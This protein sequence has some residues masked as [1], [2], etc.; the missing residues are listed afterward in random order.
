MIATIFALFRCG[1]SVALVNPRLYPHLRSA[2]VRNLIYD[3]QGQVLSGGRNIRFDMSWLPA[4]V[5]R[6]AARAPYRHR[7][8]GDGNLISFTSGTTGAAE[9][10]YAAYEEPVA[11]LQFAGQPR[12]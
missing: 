10:D 3:T 5:L 4:P 12:A 7:P 2:G 9:A 6:A 1:F 8:A 11:T